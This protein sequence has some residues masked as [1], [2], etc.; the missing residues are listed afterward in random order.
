MGLKKKETHLMMMADSSV[1]R[2][3][4]EFKGHREH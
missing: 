2:Q 4:F 1:L 3:G